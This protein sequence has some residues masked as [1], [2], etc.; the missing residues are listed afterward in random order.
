MV[1]IGDG[2]FSVLMVGDSCCAA[3]TSGHGCYVVSM[4]GGGSYAI[5]WT[6]DDCRVSNDVVLLRV[7]D[8][9]RRRKKSMQRC[10]AAVSV[11]IGV[12]RRVGRGEV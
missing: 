6:D 4:R 1:F 2:W 7:A 9:C 8:G 11:S 3:S 5:S 10:W 12:K